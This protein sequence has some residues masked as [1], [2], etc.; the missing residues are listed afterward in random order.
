[1]CESIILNI[2]A[3]NVVPSRRERQ[4]KGGGV[5]GEE[6]GPVHSAD[7]EPLI[8]KGDIVF[9][10]FLLLRG[11][12][13]VRGGRQTARPAAQDPGHAGGSGVLSLQSARQPTPP[14]LIPFNLCFHLGRTE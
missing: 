6:G 10:Y 14:P 1:M 5:G 4:E 3:L 9:E 11:G 2:T 8:V 7:S 12:G 13:A